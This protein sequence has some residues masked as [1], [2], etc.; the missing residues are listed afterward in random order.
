MLLQKWYFIIIKSN[1]N[2]LVNH[3]GVNQLINTCTD[4]TAGLVS[5]DAYTSS[6]FSVCK[7]NYTTFFASKLPIFHYHYHHT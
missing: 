3:S 4:Y 7:F 1:S 6:F 5:I 2:L